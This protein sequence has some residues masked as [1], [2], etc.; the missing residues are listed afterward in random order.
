MKLTIR[1]RNAWWLA[2]TIAL[3][4]VPFGSSESSTASARLPRVPLSLAVGDAETESHKARH[5]H[6]RHKP[7]TRKSHEHVRWT[8]PDDTVWSKSGQLA[9]SR[10]LLRENRRHARRNEVVMDDLSDANA[11]RTRVNDEISKAHSEVSKSRAMSDALGRMWQEMRH[12]GGP[13]L[14]ESLSKKEDWLKARESQIKSEIKHGEAK[15]K[16]HIQQDQPTISAYWGSFAHAKN[17]PNKTD[18]IGKVKGDESGSS[19]G[20]SSSSDEEE[21]EENQEANSEETKNHEEENQEA[22]S[23]ETKIHSGVVRIAVCPHVVTAILAAGS[24]L[25]MH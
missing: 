20:S 18:D 4:N 7:G 2:S 23:E 25:A 19:S 22:N 3:V 21:E 5:H 16:D 17:Q 10:I 8:L 1:I 12:Y 15:L 6:H 24:L 11:F 14:S 13:F 9:A